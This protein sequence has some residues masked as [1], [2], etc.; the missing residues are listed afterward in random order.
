MDEVN[1]VHEDCQ[2]ASEVSMVCRVCDLLTWAASSYSCA[3]IMS[4]VKAEIIS[5]FQF[6]LQ[7]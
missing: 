3:L 1:D 4:T 2:Q 6:D 7:S 5:D